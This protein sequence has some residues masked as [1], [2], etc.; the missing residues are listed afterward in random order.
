VDKAMIVQKTSIMYPW[1]SF[2]FATTHCDVVI[3][4]SEWD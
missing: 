1:P 3:R 4:K 2:L